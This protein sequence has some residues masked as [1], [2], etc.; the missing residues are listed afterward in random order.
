MSEDLVQD[1]RETAQ[2]FNSTAWRRRDGGQEWSIASIKLDNAA[3]QIEAQAEEIK[4]LKAKLIQCSPKTWHENEAQAKRIAK[5]EAAL[6]EVRR[7]V[8]M[9]SLGLPEG[10]SDRM[11]LSALHRLFDAEGGQAT[12]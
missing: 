3:D 10:Y 11:V 4:R 2:A 7:L 5:L 12:S 6:A 8:R 1:L 9:H